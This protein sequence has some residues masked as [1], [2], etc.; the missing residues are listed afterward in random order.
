MRYSFN[1]LTCI[2]CIIVRIVG[3]YFF[4]DLPPVDNAKIPNKNSVTSSRFVQLLR[5]F[6]LPEL[7]IVMPPIVANNINLM[8][9][10]ARPHTGAETLQWLENHFPESWIGN[11]G[12]LLHWPARSP[13]L[14]HSFYFHL[15]LYLQVFSKKIF[16]LISLFFRHHAIS[17]SGEHYVIE[18]TEGSQSI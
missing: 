17:P 3:P 13:D 6:M 12:P 5:L 7:P 14:V 2:N 18:F 11:G 16:L 9:D 10:G 1:K 8:L 15:H 4:S